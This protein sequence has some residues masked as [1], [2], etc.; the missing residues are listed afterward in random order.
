MLRDYRS[1]FDKL[2]EERLQKSI[3][4]LVITAGTAT[5][6]DLATSFDSKPYAN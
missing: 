3:R 4:T 1:R 6:I 2:T 5:A